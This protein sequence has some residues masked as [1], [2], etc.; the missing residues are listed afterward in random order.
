MTSLQS[1]KRMSSD[2]MQ[3]EI[4]MREQIDMKDIPETTGKGDYKLDI[5]SQYG[6]RVRLLEFG[7]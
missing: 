2:G 4:W 1:F 6:V 3:W 5:R 7:Y